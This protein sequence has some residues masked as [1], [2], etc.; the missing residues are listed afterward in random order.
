LNYLQTIQQIH[1]V[2]GRISSQSNNRVILQVVLQVVAVI[3][4]LPCLES[5]PKHVRDKNSVE[6]SYNELHS[7]GEK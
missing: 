7:L 3:F 4:Y 5:Y 2:E 6:V 1:F